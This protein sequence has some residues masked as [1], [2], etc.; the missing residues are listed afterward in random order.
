M[1]GT[2]CPRCVLF[3]FSYTTVNEIVEQL[4]KSRF[5]RKLKS[6]NDLLC[7]ARQSHCL[8]SLFMDLSSF[9]FDF[10]CGVA[11]S[12]S[13]YCDRCYRSVVCPSACLSV[14]LVRPAKAVGRNELPFSRDT[15]VVPSNTVLDR[16]PGPPQGRKIW[17]RNPSSQ[18]YRLSPN[19][20]DPCLYTLL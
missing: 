13:A 3:G 10:L 2:F 8:S 18:R 19:Y 1:L 12:D 14:T 5:I 4:R 9:T 11:E 20:F 6:L 17:G 7:N 15:H 16:G